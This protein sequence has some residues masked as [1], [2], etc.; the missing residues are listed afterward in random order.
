MS[1]DAK[2]IDM[3]YGIEKTPAVPGAESVSATETELQ[4]THT[5]LK[6]QFNSVTLLSMAFVICNSWAGI[7]GSIQLALLQG[8]PVTLIYSIIISTSAYLAIAASLAELASVYPT[9]G[10]Q[11]HFASILAPSRLRRVYQGMAFFA[12]VYNIFA[13]KRAPWTH[14]IGFFLTLSLF[15]TSFIVILIRASPK[16][17]STF[18]WTTFINETGWPN[19]VCFLTGLSTSCYMYNGLDASMHLAEECSEPERTVPRTI[20]AAVGIGFVTAFSYTVA[21]LYGLTD[22]TQILTTTGWIPYIVY[23]Q[24]FRSTTIANALTIIGVVMAVFIIIAVQETSSRLAWSF[25]RDEGIVF[26]KFIKRIDPRLDVPIF[27]LLSTWSLVFVCGLIYLGS[28]TAINALIGACII[29]QELSFAIPVVLLLY[30]GRSTKFLPPKRPFKMPH[31]LGWAVNIY[32]VMFTILTLV[33]FNLPIFIPT[34]ASTMNYACAILGVALVLGLLNWWL[35][36]KKHYN[37]PVVEFYEQA[38]CAQED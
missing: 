34:N 2:D 35:Y 8:G 7:S 33:F 36:A 23:V 27:G 17:P 29:L 22:I 15:L 26:S 28:A 38:N 1:M 24:I 5:P 19:G 12:L 4:R 13:L 20:M 11:Y 21:L 10:G 3:S 6:K 16:Q 14:N 25:A 31:V 37:G 9:A 18:V 32:V 30:Q